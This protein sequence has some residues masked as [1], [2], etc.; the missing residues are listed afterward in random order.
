MRVN[1][2]PA[3]I[4]HRYDYRETSLLLEVFSR[5]YGRVSLIAKGAKRQKRNLS[6]HITAFQ[7]LLLD[8]GGKGEVGIL[9]AADQVQPYTSL[10][11]R[12]LY[13]GLYINELV[14]KLLQR[15]DPHERLYDVY[16]E[17]IRTLQQTD[18]FEAELRIFEKVLLVELGYGLVLDRDISDNSPIRS[19]VCYRYVFDKGPIRH[20]T[21]NDDCLQ[22]SIKIDGASLL[23]LHAN[24]LDDPQCLHEA[25]QLMRAALA[26][27]L[28]G[29]QLACRKLFQPAK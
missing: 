1:Q 16:A 11:G 28:D 7:P 13:C 25:K 14:I 29:K 18:N 19:D 8:W 23:A 10:H 24:K 21:T 26:V 15:H 6:A 3:Y 17:T 9:Y 27:Q 20:E 4:L 22:Q 12:L 2:Q 5:D